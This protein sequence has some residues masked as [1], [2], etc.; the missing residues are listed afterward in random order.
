[1]ENIKLGEEDVVLRNYEYLLIAKNHGFFQDGYDSE[2]IATCSDWVVVWWIDEIGKLKENKEQYINEILPAFK[3]WQK[4]GIKSNGVGFV[5][6]YLKLAEING[7]KI[8][9]DSFECISAFPKIREK[10][11]KTNFKTGYDKAVDYFESMEIIN[12]LKRFN[13]NGVPLL[14]HTAYM[15]DVLLKL[16]E[17]GEIIDFDT[18]IFF[19]TM[20]FVSDERA[21]S[22]Y[23]EKIAI[24]NKYNYKIVNY[25]E[26]SM[27]FAWVNNYGGYNTTYVRDLENKISKTRDN[28]NM[29]SLKNRT[30]IINRYCY[31]EILVSV[32]E[33]ND[34][35][36]KTTKEYQGKLR[37]CDK[38]SITFDCIN[39]E[40][41]KEETI[42]INNSDNQII[43]KIRLK[44]RADSLYKCM[45]INDHVLIK[46]LQAKIKI[47]K[48]QDTFGQYLNAF[49]TIAGIAYLKSSAQAFIK[50]VPQYQLPINNLFAFCFERV[51]MIEKNPDNLIKYS[52]C[53][54]DD[55]LS[56]RIEGLENINFGYPLES[57]LSDDLRE[58][59]KNDCY[60]VLTTINTNDL[61]TVA[62]KT[63]DPVSDDKH[64]SID[65]LKSQ[66]L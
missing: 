12:N 34:Q 25:N 20:N 26:L 19:Y 41:N 50:L 9:E 63:D 59:I 54:Y 32:I 7:I 45:T 10:R 42:T 53:L 56:G 52:K 60:C 64:Y 16:E 43:N 21:L 8:D 57:F 33:L 46:K 24:E 51:Y 58:V 49:G 5:Y 30:R 3:R 29:R 44:D 27:L 23:N 13:A 61:P 35:G 1:M 6:N 11:K 4:N 37:A 38:N 31:R 22:Y 18:F 65:D 2:D 15:Y 62:L 14:R 36:E 55:I 39:P 66:R 47:V 28:I 40:T 17:Q 48:N